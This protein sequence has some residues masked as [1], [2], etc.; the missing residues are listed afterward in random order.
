MHLDSNIERFISPNLRQIFCVR[1]E[2][3]LFVTAPGN[4]FAKQINYSG[5]NSTLVFIRLEV[6]YSMTVEGFK[7][8]VQ[9]IRRVSA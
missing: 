7:Q 2:T 1:I 4:L 6:S 5:S 8:F 9:A 3:I